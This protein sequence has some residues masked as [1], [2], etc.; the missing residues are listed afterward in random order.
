MLRFYLSSSA[1]F[2]VAGIIC[3]GATGRPEIYIF[4]KR[5]E[6]WFMGGRDCQAQGIF[7]YAEKP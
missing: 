3:R 4:K 7:H 2:F 5:V 1:E 6:I